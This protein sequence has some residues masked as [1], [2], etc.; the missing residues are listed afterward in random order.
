M[1]AREVCGVAFC[2]ATAT[3]RL[4]NRDLAC[5]LALDDAT[6]QELKR[7]GYVFMC[8]QHAD[9]ATGMNKVR[10]GA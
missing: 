2:Q 4:R 6:A 1:P 5:A 8:D 3:R 7:G 9:M 10:R